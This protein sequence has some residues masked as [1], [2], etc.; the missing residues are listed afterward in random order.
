MP[1][2]AIIKKLE[3][4]RSEMLETE[5]SVL[6]KLRGLNANRRESA[7]NLL[8]YL[9]LRRHDIRQLQDE[10]SSIGLSSLGRCE[11]HVISSIDSILRLFAT[12]EPANSESTVPTPSDGYEKG[13]LLLSAHTTALLGKKPDKRNVYI[14]V[15]MPVEAA[16]NFELVRQLVKNGMNCMRINCA[17]DDAEVWSGMVSNL[18]KAIKETG[19]ECRVLMDL[20]G[21]K[22]RTGPVA[23]GPEIIKCRPQR[24]DF[25]LVSAPARLWLTAADNVVS[26]KA[27]ADACIPIEGGGLTEL[28]E[29][30]VTK[31]FDA[32]GASRSLKIVAREDS[33]V[34]AELNKTAYLATNTT[35]HAVDS[36]GVCLPQKN[37]LRV[38]QLPAKQQRIHLHVGDRLVLTREL[39]PGKPA[40]VS[41]EGTTIHAARI[42]VTLPELFSSVRER[43]RILID[44]GKISGVARTV[45]HD[46]VEVEITHAPLGGAKIGAD[47]GI[48]L[49]DGELQLTALTD[50]DKD[51]LPFIAKHADMIGYSFVDSEQAVRELQERLVR[52]GGEN[53]G[54]VLKIESKRA[55]ERL[56]GLLLAAMGSPAAGVMIARGDLAVE[57]GF[58]RL[59]ELQE[60]ILWVCEAAHMPVIWATQ[61]LENLAKEGLPSRSEVTDAAMGVRA[62][63][64]MLNKGDYIVEA[65]RSLDDILQRMQYHQSKK[66]SMLRHLKLAD[67][68]LSSSL[69]NKLM[70]Q[71]ANS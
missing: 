31:F 5:T 41:S 67:R 6:E 37:E 8:H 3:A 49:P 30:S 40:I 34:W 69:G 51:T 64:V 9:A 20:P 54:I 16:T 18:R 24:N 33:G 7:K 19:K 52:L 42:G 63:C 44:D 68:N 32:R 35:F 57:C 36:D 47:K 26:P 29:G 2:S 4:L 14:M 10:L 22:L 45:S 71:A 61:V 11:S 27:P 53:I 55:F 66:K 58:E 65:V 62:E 43:E 59:A 1:S 70:K 38:G 56:P 12:L 17:H 15:T 50:L 13:R 28:R 21:P 60:E 25:G 23:S 48:N 46:E 39:T